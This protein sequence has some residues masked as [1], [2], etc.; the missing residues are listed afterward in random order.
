MNTKKNF[1]S[2]SLLFLQILFQTSHAEIIKSTSADTQLIEWKL[3][4]HNLELKLIQRL[5]D[6][7]RSFFEARGFPKSITNEIA[8]S[9]V[10][11]TITRNKSIDKSQSVHVSLRQW[12]IKINHETRPLKLKEDWEKQWQNSQIKASS[13]LAFRWATFPT[14]QSFEPSGDYN[15]GMISFGLP[16]GSVFDLYIEWKNNDET[17]STWIKNISCPSNR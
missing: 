11:Q 16:P 7:T 3:T 17:R 13:K 9:C 15:W 6:Q 2:L 14:E 10:F 4:D 8:N 1:L 5:P 12:R